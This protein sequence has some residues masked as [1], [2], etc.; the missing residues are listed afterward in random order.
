MQQSSPFFDAD[1]LD[2][3]IARTAGDRGHI[4]PRAL[5]V[6]KAVRLSP[7]RVVACQLSRDLPDVDAELIGSSAYIGA[8]RVQ[9]VAPEVVAAPVRNLIEQVD[10]YTALR[11]SST[12]QRVSESLILPT[13]KLIV[14]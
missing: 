12:Q 1:Q 4:C 6:C 9:R 11:G 2:V 14:R 5:G 10:L 3:K 13:A 7:D 8:S